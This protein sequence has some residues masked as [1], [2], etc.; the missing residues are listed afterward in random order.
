MGVTLHIE[1]AERGDGKVVLRVMGV[2]ADGERRGNVVVMDSAR[3]LE[4]VFA[5]LSPGIR[6]VLR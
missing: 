2:R 5:L 4:E 6:E 3:R 1:N